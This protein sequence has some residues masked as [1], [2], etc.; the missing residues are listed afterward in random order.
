[1]RIDFIRRLRETRKF[2][3]PEQ[4]ANQLRH[5]ESEARNALTLPPVPGSL[6]G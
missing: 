3:S 4:L 1:V 2:A 6:K 5:D